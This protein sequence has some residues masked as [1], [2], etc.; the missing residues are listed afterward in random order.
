MKTVPIVI[1]TKIGKRSYGVM[2]QQQLTDCCN[3]LNNTTGVSLFTAPQIYGAMMAMC[4]A[5]ALNGQAGKS[6]REHLNVML[7]DP[8]QCTEERFYCYITANLQRR[9]VVRSDGSN[10]L[11]YR[12]IDLPER[13]GMLKLIRQKAGIWKIGISWEDYSGDGTIV[14]Y[15]QKVMGCFKWDPTT[16]YSCTDDLVSEDTSVYDAHSEVEGSGD[17]IDAHDSVA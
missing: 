16:D 5:S 1:F 14:G 6:L 9:V 2:C 8:D 17:S 12:R 10:I 11:S 15:I 3:R 4:S 13:S 7:H